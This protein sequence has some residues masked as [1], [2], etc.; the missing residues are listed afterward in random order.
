[1]GSQHSAGSDGRSGGP[2]NGEETP[3]VRRSVVRRAVAAAAMG[4][5][6]EWYDFSVVTVLSAQFFH[7]YYD[8]SFI[9]LAL[10][11]LM[12]TPGGLFLGPLG[13]KVGRKNILIV[14]VL[15]MSGGTFLMGLLP[16]F[17]GRYSLGYGAL[18]LAILLRMAQGFSTGGEYVGAAT[19]MAEYAPARKRGFYGSFLEVGTLT[20]YIVG[21]LV[22]LAVTV[23]PMQPFFSAWGWRIPFLLALPFGLIGLY[24]RLKLED[25]PTFRAAVESSGRSEKPPLRMIITGHWRMILNLMGIVVLLNVADYMLLT[26]MPWYFKTTLSIDDTTSK[27]ILALVEAIM[28]VTLPF[29]GALS[30]RAGRKPLLKTSAIGFIGLSYPCFWLMQRDNTSYRIIGFLVMG[31]LLA[32]LLAV[33][34][35]TF[36]AM[37]PTRLR[38]GAMAIGY[39]LPTTLFGGTTSLIVRFLLPA[40]G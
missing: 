29:L 33:I 6:M 34:A 20:G 18:A 7:G 3:D 39:N 1:M 15:M 21:I 12:R 8:V 2:A 11:F 30:D 32:L 13:D 10:S 40:T 37:F 38:Y 14:T 31:L 23:G 25:T 16:T 4:N 28:L 5:A 22:V 26:T 36:P 35:S 19:F 17:Y 24:L 27:L 9:L